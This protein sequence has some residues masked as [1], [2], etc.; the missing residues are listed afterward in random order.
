M[1]QQHRTSLALSKRLKDEEWHEVSNYNSYMISNFGRVKSLA[2]K[3]G[4]GT[5]KKDRIL[6]QYIKKGYAV[7]ALS[8]NGNTKYMSVHR[9]VAWH[10]SPIGH[11]DASYEVNHLDG[12][13]LNNHYLNLEWTTKS[14]NNIHAR[15][16][17]LMGGERTN[18]AKLT[19]KQV[20]DIRNSYPLIDMPRLAEKY[21]V[22]INCISKIINRKTWRYV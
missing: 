10:F 11:Y 13:K 8:K 14:L 17:G 7:V 16:M 18:T 4:R 6:T 20:I 22:G 12:N 1:N 3:N 9:L 15:K 19:L 5:V 21:H 2:R